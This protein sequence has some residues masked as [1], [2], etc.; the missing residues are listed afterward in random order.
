MNKT[1]NRHGS[2]Q[3][4]GGAEMDKGDG[5]RARFMKKKWAW[6]ISGG[7]G[8]LSSGGDYGGSGGDGGASRDGKHQGGACGRDDHHDGAGNHW[9]SNPIS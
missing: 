8:L 6:I 5:W 2:F 3:E 9:R 4:G 7:A 1:E